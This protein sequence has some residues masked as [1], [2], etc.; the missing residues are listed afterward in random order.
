MIK[1]QLDNL[2]TPQVEFEMQQQPT[3]EII[4][5]YQ[6]VLEDHGINFDEILQIS[7]AYDL[8]RKARRNNP[9]MIEHNSD[10]HMH[11]YFVKKF[12]AVLEKVK[13]QRNMKRDEIM[14]IDACLMLEEAVEDKLLEYYSYTDND[15]KQM[16]KQLIKINRQLYLN[17]MKLYEKEIQHNHLEDEIKK[18]REINKALQLK[19]DQEILRNEKKSKR[20]QELKKEVEGY[21]QKMGV[22]KR[23]ARIAQRSE[24][25]KKKV[26]EKKERPKLKKFIVAQG[27]IG[28]TKSKSLT[29]KQIKQ[30]ISDMFAQKV[31]FDR[32]CMD[33]KIPRETMEQY[34]Y[35]YFNQKYGLKSLIVENITNLINSMQLYKNEDH[36]IVLFSKVLKNE[37]DEEFHVIQVQVKETL[38]SLLRIIIKERF[39]TKPESGIKAIIEQVN[40]GGIEVWMQNRILDRMYEPED[41]EQ[42]RELFNKQIAHRSGMPIQQKQPLALLESN[43]QLAIQKAFKK[44]KLSRE[45]QN[46]LNNQKETLLFTDFMKCILDFQLQ[47]HQNFLSK[48]SEIFKSLDHG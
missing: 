36:D 35:T 45:E 11:S 48:F 28:Q 7:K 14:N 19:Y 9:N 30:V 40:A 29:L 20:I 39:P 3:T 2:L 47:E 42:L 23:D 43:L 8:L 37:C 10:K 1:K 18:V 26:V 16:Q 27:A 34:M 46:Q 38:Q 44:Q 17:C 32:K 12:K 6:N 22:L 15:G 4:T 25:I 41:Q 5:D 33:T 13:Q 24:N 31:K 21:K